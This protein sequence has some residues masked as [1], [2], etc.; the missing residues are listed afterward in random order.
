MHGEG[1][2]EPASG[3][4]SGQLPLHPYAPTITTA[5][6]RRVT[7]AI[8]GEPPAATRATNTGGECGLRQ[9]TQAQRTRRQARQRPQRLADTLYQRIGVALRAIDSETAAVHYQ[10][11]NDC[12]PVTRIVIDDRPAVAS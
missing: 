12:P 4:A 7:S 11:G 3:N 5:K 1:A 10:A 2:R 8:N 6:T 9:R